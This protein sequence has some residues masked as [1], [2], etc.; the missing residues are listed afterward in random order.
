VPSGFNPQRS[1]TIGVPSTADAGD[2][3]PVFVVLHGAGI[4]ATQMK[5][6]NDYTE[7]AAERGFIAVYPQGLW[8]TWNISGIC[9]GLASGLGVNDLAFLDHVF[10]NLSARPDVDTSRMYI[11]GYSNGAMMATHFACTTSRPIAGLAATAGPVWNTAGCAGKDL[12]VILHHG[13]PDV[14]VPYNGGQG[15]GSIAASQAFRSAPTNAADLANR[16]GCTGTPVDTTVAGTSYTQ[17][18]YQDCGE[19]KVRFI[20]TDHQHVWPNS[21]NYAADVDIVNYLGL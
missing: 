5:W 11:G 21:P 1:Y 3:L 20:T 4:S 18:D 15:V 10:A 8:D 12:D 17:R 14:I 7:L 9:C 16:L 6:A 13:T 19:N 2:K